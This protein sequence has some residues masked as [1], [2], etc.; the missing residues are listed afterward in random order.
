MIDK[1]QILVYSQLDGYTFSL[2]PS[3]RKQIKKEFPNAFP[4]SNLNISF[5][6]YN[7]FRV[8]KG[9][10]ED[11]IYPIILGVSEQDLKTKFKEII[12][13]DPRTNKTLHKVKN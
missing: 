12:F 1:V 6:D 4:A 2:L 7:D 3:T 11:H 9:N 8:N 13:I 10:L 5:D